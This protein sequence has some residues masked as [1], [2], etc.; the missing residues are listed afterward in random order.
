MEGKWAR[1]E[2][3][4]NISKQKLALALNIV[5][6]PCLACLRRTFSIQFLDCDV[7]IIAVTS[8]PNA[9]LIQI[10]PQAQKPALHFPWLAWFSF[11]L[12]DRYSDV[13]QN[14]CLCNPKNATKDAAIEKRGRGS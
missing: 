8:L 1:V 9:R 14:A 7:S 4:L 10:A 2:Q 3:E 6:C 5:F 12:A 13:T 11:S